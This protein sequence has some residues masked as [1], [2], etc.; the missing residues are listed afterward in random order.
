MQASNKKDERRAMDS[1]DNDEYV[2]PK[3]TVKT[4]CKCSLTKSLSSSVSKRTIW[5]GGLPV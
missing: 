2:P 5:T 1:E 3:K 4:V